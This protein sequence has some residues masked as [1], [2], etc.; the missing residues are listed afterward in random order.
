M[1]NLTTTHPAI[2]SKIT[3]QMAVYVGTYGK[4]N[5]GSLFGAWIDLTL[6]KDEEDFNELCSAIHYL[7]EDPEF[8][9]QDWQSIP[10]K[11]I[12]EDGLTA[13][14]WDYLEAYNGTSNTEALEKFVSYGYNPEDF[15]SYYMGEYDNEQ[16]YAEQLLAETG[17]LDQIP[18]HLRYYF[19]YESFARDLFINDYLFIDGSVFQ[20]H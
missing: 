19:D 12:S 17:D 5:E 6:I 13:S 9:F 10:S 15:S 2:L 1:E 16:E 4:Y 11:Y 8:M 14:F 7:E 3:D 20:Q 18:H